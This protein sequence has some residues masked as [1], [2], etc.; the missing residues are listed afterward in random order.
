MNAPVNIIWGFW[1]SPNLASNIS[2]H[3]ALRNY[4][5]TKSQSLTS[6]LTITIASATASAHKLPVQ[7]IISIYLTKITI[8]IIYTLCS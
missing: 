8:T 3:N 5:F 1:R 7:A 4:H 6:V 2:T